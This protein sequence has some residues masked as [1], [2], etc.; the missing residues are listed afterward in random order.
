[1]SERDPFDLCPYYREK[2]I[3][4]FLNEC[5]CHLILGRQGK[6]YGEI[7]EF[8]DECL[9]VGPEIEECPCTGDATKCPR[10]SLEN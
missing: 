4:I 6:M 9:C 2:K 3:T 5:D 7:Y 8:K 1:M 10:K